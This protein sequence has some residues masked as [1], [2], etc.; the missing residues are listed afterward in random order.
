MQLV[1]GRVHSASLV[2]RPR[3]AT[4]VQSHP[5]AAPR[6]AVHIVRLWQLRAAEVSFMGMLASRSSC[7]RT[8]CPASACSAAQH[9]TR[10]LGWAALKLLLLAVLVAA[11]R[12]SSR[13]S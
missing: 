2:S 3:A 7:Y 1:F 12:C 9:N 5:A 10:Y 6:Q 13:Y 4:R 11:G 8:L